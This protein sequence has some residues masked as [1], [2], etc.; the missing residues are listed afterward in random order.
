[1]E[2]RIIKIQFRSVFCLSNL[3][4][5]ISI[6]WLTLYPM[7]RLY[8]SSVLD[9]L[10]C[11]V[12][13]PISASYLLSNRWEDENQSKREEEEKKNL[14]VFAL[15]DCNTISLV[16]LPKKQWGGGKKSYIEFFFC[17]WFVPLVSQPFLRWGLTGFDFRPV[18][19]SRIYTLVDSYFVT[20]MLYL[21]TF[22]KINSRQILGSRW[23]D[24][25]L[26]LC[27]NWTYF[28]C[29]SDLPD[30]NLVELQ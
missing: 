7:C 22:M 21:L 3:S 17:T 4:E 1:M 5:T 10:A 23:T 19:T 26:N 15:N 27:I 28:V 12:C 29:T 30:F 2:R 16:L 11:S 20:W 18:L 6:R 24:A 14:N 25:Q 9:W 13:F 8:S